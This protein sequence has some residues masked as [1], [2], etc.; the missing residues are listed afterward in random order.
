MHCPSCHAQDTKVIET[1]ILQNGMA[2]RRRRR[3]EDCD[4]RFT[5]Y[6]NFTQQLPAI[7]KA[8]GRRENFNREKIVKGLTKACQKRPVSRDQIH[9][10]ID[11]LERH[12]GELSLKEISSDLLGNYVMEELYKLDPVSY[13]RFASFYWE[14][15]NIE[16]FVSNLEKNVRPLNPLADTKHLNVKGT[17]GESKRPQ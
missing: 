16:D 13:V 8:D 17:P 6:E 1:R 7:V 5:T 15:N 9:E 14:F 12:L 2:V 11:S 10:L 3:C 4:K